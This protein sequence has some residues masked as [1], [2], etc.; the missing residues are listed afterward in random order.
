MTEQHDARPGESWAY[1]AR[2]V[3]DLLEVVVLRLGTQRPARLMVR[4]VDDHFEG[5]QEWVPPSRLK[6]RWEAVDGFRERERLWERVFS[7]GIDEDGPLDLAAGSMLAPHRSAHT[8]GQSLRRQRIVQYCFLALVVAL[9]IF[10]AIDT[11]MHRYINVAFATIA[12]GVLVS[13]RRR[14]IKHLDVIVLPLVAHSRHGA[15][16]GGTDVSAVLVLEDDGVVSRQR[17]I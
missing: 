16:T 4:F 13:R 11:P 3:D 2:S 8:D 17:D 10:D 9:L 12:V 14:R 7:L 1:R 6:V 5:R 15:G